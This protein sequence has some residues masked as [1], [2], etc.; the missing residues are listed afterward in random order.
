[1]ALKEL[2]TEEALLKGH[3]GFGLCEIDASALV[4]E[5]LQI[6]YEPSEEE[7]LAH[8]AVRGKLSEGLRRRLARRA[9]VVIEP[10]IP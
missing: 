2:T 10:R 3:E 4:L 7:G 5:D 1:M 8:V 6:T 9:R